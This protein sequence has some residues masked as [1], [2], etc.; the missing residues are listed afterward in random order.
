VESQRGPWAQPL[1][2]GLPP[3][4]ESF[5]AFEHWMEVTKLPSSPYLATLENCY[6]VSRLGTL[7]LCSQAVNTGVQ[8]GCHFRH[9]CLR[10][11]GR[12]YPWTQPSTRPMNTGSV[13]RAPMFTGR[14]GKKHFMTV[15]FANTAHGHRFSVHTTSVHGPSI[16]LVNMGATMDTCEHVQLIRPVSTGS[17]HGPLLIMT[18]LWHYVS[19]NVPPLQLPIIFTAHRMQALY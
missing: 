12:R 6:G 10:V 3:E 7:Y 11:H 19:K 9:P 18:S 8:H 14:V 5:L 13:Y 16:Q 4:A 15:L 2:R 1:I 17:R